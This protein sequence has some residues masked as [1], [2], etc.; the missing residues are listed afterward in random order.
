MSAFSRKYTP[1]SNRIV[2]RLYSSSNTPL[3]RAQNI[4]AMIWGGGDPAVL[5]RDTVDVAAA[6]SVYA[7]LDREARK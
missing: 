6:L 7:E 4:M 3:Q 1:P 2:A 5:E